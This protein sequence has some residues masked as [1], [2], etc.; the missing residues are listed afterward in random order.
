MIL[1]PGSLPHGHFT[2]DDKDFCGHLNCILKSPFFKSRKRMAGSG[3]VQIPTPTQ[4][5]QMLSSKITDP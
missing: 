5:H 4:S 2:I 1:P 3:W